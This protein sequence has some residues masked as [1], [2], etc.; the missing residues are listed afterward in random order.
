M[1]KPIALLCVLALLVSL[2]G[3]A[4]SPAK[5]SASEAPPASSAPVASSDAPAEADPEDVTLRM[6][7]W[8]SQTRHDNNIKNIETYMARNPHVTIEYEFS[9]FDGYFDKAAAM[10]TAGNLPDVWQ[11]STGYILTYGGNNQIIDMN[12]Y[13]EDGTIDLSDWSEPFK[14][15]GRV[16]GKTFGLPAGGSAYCMLYNPEIFAEAGLEEPGLTWT[17][18]EYFTAMTTIREKTGLWGDT[19]FP[20]S[21]HEGFVHFLRQ[22]GY[23]G[24]YNETGDGLSFDDVNLWIELFTKHKEAFATG[25]L[26]PFDQAVNLDKIELTG[27]ATGE[28]GILGVVSASQAVAASKA[29]GKELRM[30]SMPSAPD[31]VQPGNWT[32]LTVYF[33][34]STNTVSER[35]SAKLVNYLLNDIDAAKVTLMETGVPPSAKTREAVEPLLDATAQNVSKYV[36]EIAGIAPPYSVITP[37][38]HVRVRDLLLKLIQDMMYDRISIEDAGNQFIPEANKL[39]AEAAAGQ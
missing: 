18:D 20:S 16:D 23:P 36:G 14:V 21:M 38:G 29:L 27:V 12:P 11:M 17:W 15:M 32:G 8:G 26:M 25:A 4:Q 39:F 6:L 31:Q 35:E 9:G 13:I 1:K 30:V 24:L 22:N 28:A 34:I 10:A 3:C 19:Q 37:V 5:E 7:W 2:F 33:S